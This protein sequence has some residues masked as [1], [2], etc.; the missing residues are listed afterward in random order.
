[1]SE[2]QN[3]PVT[4]S[5]DMS[6]VNFAYMTENALEALRKHFHIEM[7]IG[8]LQTCQA[9]YRLLRRDPTVDE[10]YM[11]D[12]LLAENDRL[13]STYLP[14]EMK[15]DCTAIAN[16]FADM[17]ARRSDASLKKDRPASL[18]ELASLAEA[19]L[20]AIDKTS[21]PLDRVAVRFTNHR[22]LSLAA[23]GYLRTAT[24]G[25]EEED[26]AIGI[27]S[28]ESAFR[29]GKPAVGDYVYAILQD[30]T[31]DE[32]FETRLVEYLCDT[33]VKK[34]VK[35]AFFLCEETPLSALIRTSMGLSLT[36]SA[37]KRAEG[38]TRSLVTKTGAG[39][40]LVASPAASADLL[41]LAQE[42]G[43]CV[44]LVA[45]VTPGDSIRMPGGQVFP[46]G[47]FP[48]ML[49][50]RA[51]STEIECNS[52]EPANISLSRI[53]TCTLNGQKHAVV[54][55]DASS[56]NSYAASVKGL[57][58]A[59][60]HCLA[61][62][63]DPKDVGLSCHLTL[64]MAPP[65]PKDL[66]CS[67][68]AILGLY[69]VQME[70]E[71]R[72]NAPVLQNKSGEAPHTA[73]A[74]IAPL[75][76]KALPPT[77]VGGGSMIYYLEPLYDENG[78]PVFDDLK[79]MYGYIEKL[80]TDGLILSIRPTSED[81]L[82]DLDAMSRDA[83]VEYVREDSVTSH[84]GGFLVETASRIQGTLVAQTSLPQVTEETEE[85]TPASEVS[86]EI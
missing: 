76:R 20:R 58:Y 23:D 56:N 61:A 7:C 8:A 84:F 18:K 12:A 36:E 54:K 33:N 37:I 29:G 27:R 24:T 74:M 44:R 46:H 62:G 30:G 60:S 11:L 86:A 72:G 47:F 15:T 83:T 45:K 65:S 69:R 16:T 79:K 9:Q 22:E 57:I 13:P 28:A 39:I 21:N 53:G 78:L 51:Y 32:D 3:A 41:L 85:P 25:G 82:A 42:N 14:A 81:L 66:G 77:V 75:S 67:L 4:P 59:L 34:A 2:N 68:G 55:V 48:A 31:Q 40:V 5:S 26:I 73:I 38:S 80:Y 49:P 10:L 63:V 71:L 64:P 43:F 6:F 1:M 50:G 19:Y 35:C 52:A 17:M 70:F